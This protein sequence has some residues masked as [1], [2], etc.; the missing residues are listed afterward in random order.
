MMS[1]KKVSVSVRASKCRRRTR[2]K[3]IFLNR[4]LI[5]QAMN[6][7]LKVCKYRSEK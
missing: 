6:L 1:A 2:L 7:S 3:K 4:L 5:P